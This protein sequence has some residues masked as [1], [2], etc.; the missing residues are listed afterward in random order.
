MSKKTIK[1]SY[2]L[3]YG[4]PREHAEGVAKGET[5][6]LLMDELWTQNAY[7][8]K[9]DH[10]WEKIRRGHEEWR[11]EDFDVLTVTVSLF[12]IQDSFTRFM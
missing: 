8:V 4:Q 2:E 11:G 9:L 12:T 7:S 3:K 5:S 10:E 1:H 6:R